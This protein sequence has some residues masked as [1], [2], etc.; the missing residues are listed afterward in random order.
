MQF[1]FTSKQ[2]TRNTTK[3]V[4]ELLSSNRW[5]SAVALLGE[6]GE[7]ILA[8][9]NSIRIVILLADFDTLLVSPP[10]LGMISRQCSDVA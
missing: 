9:L 2:G 7:S 10:G 5:D 8:L 4:V 3:D 1:L 6:L